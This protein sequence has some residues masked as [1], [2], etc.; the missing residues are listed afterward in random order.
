MT[1]D[2]PTHSRLVHGFALRVF[3]L[4]MMCA[5][6]LSQAQTITMSATDG[7]DVPDSFDGLFSIFF[8]VP[9][10]DVYL[11]SFT[12][13]GSDGVTGRANGVLYMGDTFESAWEVPFQDPAEGLFDSGGVVVDGVWNFT[14][15]AVVLSAGQ[16]YTFAIANSNPLSGVGVNGS[17]PGSG[18]GG[19]WNNEGVVW[20]GFALPRDEYAE[21]AFFNFRLEV[22]PIPEPANAAL[23]L[24]VVAL[25][26]LWW[27]RR[28]APFQ[29]GQ[30]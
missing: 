29:A 6:G 10:Q 27:R 9:D 30:S 2:R 18:I 4:L 19:T 21:N 5:P 25:G 23:T 14:P 8:Y 22:T 1:H 13:L 26:G 7:T 15:G 3:A 11:N 24:G 16:T 28:R 12:Y 17:G 20:M